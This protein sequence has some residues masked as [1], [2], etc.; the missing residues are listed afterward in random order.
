M[1][2]FVYI[3]HR[4]TFIHNVRCAA[5]A[6]VNCV[7][8]TANS[9]QTQQQ[10]AELQLKSAFWVVLEPHAVDDATCL[11]RQTCR[12]AHSQDNIKINMHKLE[13]GA[14]GNAYCFASGNL[15]TELFIVTKTNSLPHSLK[16]CVFFVYSLYCYLTIVA[17]Y[18]LSVLVVSV[19][20]SL[21]R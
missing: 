20:I 9:T 1:H 10:A 21:I 14:F 16:G 12:F 5:N 15:L 19:R 6:K 8:D 4:I 13:R 7:S 17:D 2:T 3:R 11:Q 18:S